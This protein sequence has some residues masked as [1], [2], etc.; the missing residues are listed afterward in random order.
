MHT[1]GSTASTAD[2]GVASLAQIGYRYEP[3]LGSIDLK[4]FKVTVDSKEVF[5]G[6]NSTANILNGLLGSNTKFNISYNIEQQKLIIVLPTYTSGNVEVPYTIEVNLPNE[7]FIKKFNNL[8]IKYTDN[9]IYIYIDDT[10]IKSENILDVNIRYL[11]T[12][13]ELGPINAFVKNLDFNCTYTD[14]VNVSNLEYNLPLTDSLYEK[15]NLI[16]PINYNARFLTTPQ[17]IDNATNKDL[18]NNETL[19]IVN[20]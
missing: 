14:G 11:N 17:L 16:Q 8:R 4:Q 2:W 15:N 7:E 18:F 6:S 9:K 13:L 12:I 20:F 19:R 5:S 3:F 10:L 1:Q